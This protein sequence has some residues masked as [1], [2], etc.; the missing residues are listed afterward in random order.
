[1]LDLGTMITHLDDFELHDPEHWERYL[2]AD[3]TSQSF[4]SEDLGWCLPLQELVQRPDS[5]CDELLSNS[6]AQ[7]QLGTQRNVC[8]VSNIRATSSAPRGCLD[9]SLALAKTRCLEAC[10]RP[11][12]ICVRPA[13]EERLIRL[14]ISESTESE[15]GPMEVIFYQGD[16]LQLWRE[17]RV[18]DL[19]P[20][21]WLPLSLPYDATLFFE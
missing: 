7:A 14:S 4:Q 2:L 15:T 9:P 19:I 6:S 3:S 1:M 12:D 16:R 21:T 10:S 5:C 20:P 11:G 17:T 18:V 13:S 8:F